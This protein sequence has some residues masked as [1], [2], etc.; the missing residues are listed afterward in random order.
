VQ[1]SLDERTPRKNKQHRAAKLFKAPIK[2]H[3]GEAR[4]CALQGFAKINGDL[5]CVCLEKNQKNAE[6]LNGDYFYVAA[7][8]ENVLPALVNEA[9]R[10]FLKDFLSRDFYQATEHLVAKILRSTHCLFGV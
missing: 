1:S 10:H 8:Y 9:N 4:I 3:R 6:K 7:S 2:K 5:F